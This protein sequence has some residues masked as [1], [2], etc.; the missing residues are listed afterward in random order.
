LVDL[1]EL[2]VPLL[3]VGGLLAGV[4]VLVLLW[5]RVLLV[6]VAPFEDFAQDSFRDL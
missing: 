4:G 3:D 1:H 5:G 2:L 6:V